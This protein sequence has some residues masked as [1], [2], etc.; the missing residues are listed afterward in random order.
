MVR[1]LTNL[2]FPTPEE[3]VIHVI[4]LLVNPPYTCDSLSNGLKIEVIPE[5]SFISLLR[6]MTPIKSSNFM[7]VRV[8]RGERKNKPTIA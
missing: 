2:V 1:N 7:I 6:S 3:A 4:E 8:V 5:F